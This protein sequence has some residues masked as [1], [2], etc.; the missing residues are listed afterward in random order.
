MATLLARVTD[1]QP[2]TPILSAQVDSEFDQLVQL[3]SGATPGNSKKALI[4]VSDAGDPPLELDQ[5]GAGPVQEWYQNSLLKASITNSGQ[6]KS[7]ISTGTAPLVIASTTLV[8]NLNADQVDGIHGASFV[9]ND[10]GAQTIAGDLTISDA[11]PK[12]VLQDTTGGDDDFEFEADGDTLTL[13]VTGGSNILTV[14]GG[15]QVATFV[16]IPVLPASSP[17]TDNQAARKKYVDD[18]F[19]SKVAAGQSVVDNFKISGAAPL[20]IW[21]DTTG[22]EADWEWEAN[23]STFVGRFSGGGDLINFGQATGAIITAGDLTVGDDL[24]VSDVL[25]VNGKAVGMLRGLV[26]NTTSNSTS[27]TGEDDLTSFT[28][29]AGTLPANG[30]YI[31]FHA[32]GSMTDGGVGNTNTIRARI[33]GNQLFSVTYGENTSGDW[34]L[35]VKVI[36]LSDTSVRCVSTYARTHTN[37]DDS[38]TAESTAQV[39]D[40]SVSSL[41]GSTNIFKVTGEVTNAADS[42]TQ[43]W[44][45]GEYVQF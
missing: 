13:R 17:T 16:Q 9:R 11:T 1:F 15:T 44:L 39:N 10:N 45:G 24:T 8:T 3:L 35:E 27:G 26:S 43:K 5:I 18:N 21:E 37:F 33:A 7:E 41:S 34:A 25:Q 14:A 29:P 23:G 2:A 30:D 4:K 12:L 38:G 6:F 36:R 28:I 32:G 19:V 20:M 40:V 22:G 42:I 31:L